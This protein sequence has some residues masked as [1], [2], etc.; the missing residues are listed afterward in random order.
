M[1]V[2]RHRLLLL[3]AADFLA[4]G[5][6][7]A[8]AYGI[9]APAWTAFIFFA[10]YTR[11]SRMEDRFECNGLRAEVLELRGAVLELQQKQG[12]P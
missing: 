2:S 12:G 11:S 8:L 4:V 1:V 7:A 6:L 5:L 10:L 9:G 3:R